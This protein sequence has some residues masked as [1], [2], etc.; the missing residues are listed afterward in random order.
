MGELLFGIATLSRIW[1][2]GTLQHL[3]G[4]HDVQRNEGCGVV[5]EKRR[6]KEVEKGLEKKVFE[7]PLD[8]DQS[9]GSTLGDHHGRSSGGK[10][11]SCGR[12]GKKGRVFLWI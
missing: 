11:I 10:R 7:T 3:T 8:P 1:R 2:E 4:V 9:K 5:R 12:G 6:K